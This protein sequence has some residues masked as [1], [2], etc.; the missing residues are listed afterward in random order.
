M[1]T[2]ARIWTE[3]SATTQSGMY[4]DVT[5]WSCNQGAMTRHVLELGIGSSG[6][7]ERI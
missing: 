6:R 5:L 1:P 7:W 4:G 2:L 3:A